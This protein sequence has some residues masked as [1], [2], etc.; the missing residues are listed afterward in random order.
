MRK[1]LSIYAILGAALV[2]LYGVGGFTGWWRGIIRWNPPVD[3]AYDSDGGSRG[4]GSGVSGWPG[5][6][7]GFRGGK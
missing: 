6:S 5:G 1:A 4:G 7:G 3:S 2:V